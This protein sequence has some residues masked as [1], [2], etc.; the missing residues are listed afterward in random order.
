MG[1]VAVKIDGF[2]YNLKGTEDEKYLNEVVKYAEKKMDDLKANNNKLS[3]AA[4]AMLTAINLVDEIFKGN[5]D[6]TELLKNFETLKSSQEELEKQIADLKSENKKLLENETNLLEQLNESKDKES[7]DK[8]KQ[9]ND[10]L[11]KSYKE[12]EDNKNKILNDNKQL[13]FNLKSTKYK[14]MDMQQ[15]YFDAQIRLAKEMQS[16]N[17]LLKFNTD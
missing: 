10:E 14:L 9:E 7:Y 4:A 8:I 1:S 13:R 5:S 3:T 2:E 16:K 6:Y 11:D 12:L 15:K 17:P